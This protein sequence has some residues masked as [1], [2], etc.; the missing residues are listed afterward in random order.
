MKTINY[1]IG[2][3]IQYL[4]SLNDLTQENLAEMLNLSVK[5]ISSVERGRSC[6]SVPKLIQLCEILDCTAD[7]LILGREIQDPG[8]YI[9]RSVL[10][11]FINADKKE[12]KL[13]Q[14]YLLLFR[15]IHSTE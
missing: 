3:R 1:E 4:R 14:E 8:C 5:H 6:L 10:D 12:Q 15:K 9:P 7:Y 11:I 13:L 2:Q